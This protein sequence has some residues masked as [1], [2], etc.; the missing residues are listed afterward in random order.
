MIIQSVSPG[1]WAHLLRA[2][3]YWVHGSP[4]SLWRFSVSTSH[5]GCEIEG[6]IDLTVTVGAVGIKVKFRDEIS[7]T[8]FLRV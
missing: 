7:N 2:A 5:T 3:G 8:E 4:T 1:P 6:I